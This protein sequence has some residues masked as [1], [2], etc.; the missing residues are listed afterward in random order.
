MPVIPDQE[1]IRSIITKQKMLLLAVALALALVLML[2]LGRGGAADFA[3]WNS[4]VS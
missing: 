3:Y 4:K 1:K 2:V